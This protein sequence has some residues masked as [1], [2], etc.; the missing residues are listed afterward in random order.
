ML[1]NG[2]RALADELLAD[3]VLRRTGSEE[4]LRETESVRGLEEHLDGH[5]LLVVEDEVA[6]HGLPL[7]GTVLN[8]EAEDHHRLCRRLRRLDF[9]SCDYDGM[10]ALG[11]E[12]TET[13]VFFCLLVQIREIDF[14]S[15]FQRVR[16]ASRR[17][18]IA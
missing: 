15:F 3:L 14:H 9:S 13:A 16:V 10:L 12:S 8:S 1:D 18:P 17:S 7:V 4:L 2:D 11:D 6:P 5:G